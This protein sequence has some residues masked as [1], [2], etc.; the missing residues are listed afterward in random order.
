MIDDVGK[1]LSAQAE[2]QRVRY[3]A[4][5]RYTEIAFQVGIVIPHQRGDPIAALKPSFLQ[6]LRQQRCA[7]MKIRIAVAMDGTVWQPLNNF[8]LREEPARALQN[9]LKGKRVI[10]HRAFH[11]HLQCW[12]Q[13]LT[14]D[15]ACQATW[16][17][18]GIVKW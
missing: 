16:R 1:I 9:V 17:G 4:R 13:M 8:L 5:N 12:R 14:Q 2:I 3:P 10:H 15:C 6:G 18:F 11:T 7:A